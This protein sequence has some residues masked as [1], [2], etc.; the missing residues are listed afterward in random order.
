MLNLREIRQQKGVTQRQL[1]EKCGIAQSY[2]SELEKG[3]YDCSIT[4][5]CALTRALKVTPGELIKEEYWK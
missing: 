1:S 4:T 5:L 3:K 2:I